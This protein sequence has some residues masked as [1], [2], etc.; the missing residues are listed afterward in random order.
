M[1][2]QGARD[3]TSEGLM[4]VGRHYRRLVAKRRHDR[5]TLC[6]GFSLPEV[7]HGGPEVYLLVSDPVRAWVQ[8]PDRI[9]EIEAR[10][11]A[12]TERA[13]L[14]EWGSARAPTAPGSDATRFTASTMHR[15]HECSRCRVEVSR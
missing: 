3:A 1:A 4:S 7:A 8:F 12:H 9:L 10:V 14:V 5:W 11:L 6:D 15:L 2:S 13:V